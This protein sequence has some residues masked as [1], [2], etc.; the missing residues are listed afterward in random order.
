VVALDDEEICVIYCIVMQS[1]LLFSVFFNNICLSRLL[2]VCLDY[3]AG[4]V[5]QKN[6]GNG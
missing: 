4:L 6:P 1:A 2:I 3:V 5:K